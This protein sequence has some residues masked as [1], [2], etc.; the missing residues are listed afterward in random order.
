M[1]SNILLFFSIL[2][3][4]SIDPSR[5]GQS[6]ALRA[7]Y[8]YT[9]LET[10]LNKLEREAIPQEVRTSIGTAAW[11]SQTVVNKKV[12]FKITFP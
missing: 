4:T 7:Y 12:T 1:E 6:E 3:V 10:S 9:G 5:D 2:A 11:I 8:K